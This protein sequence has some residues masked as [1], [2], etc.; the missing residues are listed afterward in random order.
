MSLILSGVY[1]FFAVKVFPLSFH[2]SGQFLM[3]VVEGINVFLALVLILESVLAAIVVRREKIDR[4]LDISPRNDAS[5]AAGL[6]DGTQ[7]P[8]QIHIYQPRL[9]LSGQQSSVLSGSTA[10]SATGEAAQSDQPYRIDILGEEG[11]EN[12]DGEGLELE[13]LPK[14]QRRPPA[15]SATIVDLANL[16]GVDPAVLTSVLGETALEI[17]SQVQ[18]QQGQNQLSVEALDVTEAPAY[19]PP[20]TTSDGSQTTIEVPNTTAVGAI[21]ES[22]STSLLSSPPLSTEAGSMISPTPASDPSTAAATVVTVAPFEP[23]EYMP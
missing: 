7:V 9:D 1:I 4:P 17:Q 3:R 18:Q 13:I 11:T 16:Q 15:Q 2:D 21:E 23:P 6:A 5:G 20:L 22:L 14:Y 10:A 19:S 8:Q 12:N